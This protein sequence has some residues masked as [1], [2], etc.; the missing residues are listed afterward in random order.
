[1]G[2][3]NIMD[4][5]GVTVTGRILAI[6]MNNGLENIGLPFARISINANSL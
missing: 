3:F 2:P 5:Q 4:V 6:M 1:M